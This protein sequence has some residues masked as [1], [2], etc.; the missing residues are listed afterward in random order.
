MKFALIHGLRQEAR[1]NVSGQC[2]GCDQ[3][4]V[5][6]C[7]DIKVWHWA[8]KGRR[9]CDPWWENETEWHRAW[10]S[11]FPDHWQEIVHRADDGEKHIADVKTDQG[12]VIEFQH[13]PISPEER[14]SRNAFYP[15]LVWV[16]DG[17]K[18][19]RDQPQF[20][21]ALD[22]GIPVSPNSSIRRVFLTDCKLMQEW[23]SSYARVFFDFGGNE[24]W[25]LLRGQ[26]NGMP[27][28]TPLPRS[29]FI[30]VHRGAATHRF[31]DYFHRALQVASQVR[32]QAEVQPRPQFMRRTKRF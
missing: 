9:N 24:L 28:V 7:G 11:Q 8:H 23:I 19:K 21:K 25:W 12:W 31:D 18:R 5:A 17:T 20:F 13:S 30:D 32:V 1:P 22:S 15:K 2:P 6:K 16:V 3:P 26:A 4:T 27:Y 14:Q 29:E 10:K